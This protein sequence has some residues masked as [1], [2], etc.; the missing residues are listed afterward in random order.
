MAVYLKRRSIPHTKNFNIFF[1]LFVCIFLLACL[2]WSSKVPPMCSTHHER[3]VGAFRSK[4]L[5]REGAYPKKMQRRGF[6][7][8]PAAVAAARR[9]RELGLWT[10]LVRAAHQ[11]HLQCTCTHWGAP[12]LQKGHIRRH[13][14]GLA[15]LTTRVA[16]DG[17]G[18]RKVLLLGGTCDAA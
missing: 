11:A 15:R 10:K 17:D 8:H 1:A 3:H 9:N 18:Q 6:A 16:Q 7:V 13:L 2:V 14:S 12:G 5:Q 4:K